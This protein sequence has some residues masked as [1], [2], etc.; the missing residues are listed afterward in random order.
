MKDLTPV[1]EQS[2]ALEVFMRR[3]ALLLSLSAAGHAAAALP[4]TAYD[5]LQWRL[6]GPFR[7]GWALTTAGVPGDPHTFYFGAADG[8]VWKTDDDG[9]TWQPLFQ[10]QGSASVGA[11]AVAPSDPRVIWVGTG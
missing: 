10:H 3:L 11:L 4:E 6:L 1:V 5:Q 9:H 2:A 7:A 8:G